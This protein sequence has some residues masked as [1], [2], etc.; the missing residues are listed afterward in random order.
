[1]RFSTLRTLMVFQVFHMAIG[2]LNFARRSLGDAYY[3]SDSRP[4]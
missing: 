2:C 1:M 4:H 3:I